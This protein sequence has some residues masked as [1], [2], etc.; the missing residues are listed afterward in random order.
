VIDAYNSGYPVGLRYFSQ[1]S[2]GFSG[3]IRF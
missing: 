1:E 2:G 3:A